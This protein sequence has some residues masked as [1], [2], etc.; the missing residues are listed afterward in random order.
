VLGAL[1]VDKLTASRS[2]SCGL[3]TWRARQAEE[4]RLKMLELE[5]YRQFAETVERDGREFVLVRIPDRYDAPRTEV[6]TPVQIR[7]G[8]KR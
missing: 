7:R 1:V 3:A 4:K 8:R 2:A 6:P 5:H